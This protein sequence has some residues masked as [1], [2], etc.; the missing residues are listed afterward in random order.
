MRELLRSQPRKKGWNEMKYSVAYACG[1][2][3]MIQLYG[4]NSERERKIAW[5]ET[6]LCPEC[7]KA[8]MEAKREAENE[9]AAEAAV[10]RG[11]CELSGS[12]KQIAWANTIREKWFAAAEDEMD[13]AH[14]DAKAI[15][16]YAGQIAE[17]RWWIDNREKEPIYVIDEIY[18]TISGKSIF[19]E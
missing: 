10:Q 3:K 19:S 17:S 1:H 9:K 14:P 16:S 11:L 6:T 4:K 18:R 5:M 12:P 13:T 8:K 15:L 2:T 7:Y